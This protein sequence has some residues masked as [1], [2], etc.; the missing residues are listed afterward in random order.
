MIVV[1]I[2]AN[3]TKALLVISQEQNTRNSMIIKNHPQLQKYISLSIGILGWFMGGIVFGFN[4]YA[5][6]L[7][8]TFN[9]TQTEL[10]YIASSGDLGM[11]LSFPP[12]MLFDT[13]GPRVT[14]I[15]SFILTTMGF[16]LM[17]L[18]T[19]YRIFFSSNNWLLCII[20]FLASEGTMFIIIATSVVNCENFDRKHR[21]KV[22]GL[23]NIIYGVSPAIFSA[24]YEAL[25]IQ[26]HI[27]DPENQKLG[28]FMITLAVLS[29]C[30]NLYA[31]VMLET[32]QKETDKPGDVELSRLCRTNQN[33]EQANYGTE[34][35]LNKFP[36]ET[37]E[38]IN[39]RTT[40]V[41][42]KTTK[43]LDMKSW[44][45]I[46]TPEFYFIWLTCLL[47]G[48]AGGTCTNNITTVVKSAKFD[49]KTTLFTV[50]IPISAL[51][52]RFLGGAIPDYVFQKWPDIP[53]SSILLFPCIISCIGQLCF[54]FFN[55][56]YIGLILSSVLMSLAYGSFYP[57]INI[58]TIEYFGL[59]YFGQ[60]SGLIVM[61]HGIGIVV[62][63]KLFALNYET[64]SPTESSDCYGEM[65]TKWY[66]LLMAILCSCAIF[67]TLCLMKIE[68]DE[69]LQHEA[70]MNA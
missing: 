54:T 61:G 43:Q 48:G 35:E 6:A 27:E 60:N 22:L 18:A 4:A 68:K 12:G 13:F 33:G 2:G 46:Q 7:K 21:G 38:E 42:K 65:C 58:L 17:W 31:V 29:A 37:K 14:N 24:L 19:E 47:I 1:K 8:K 63:Q 5:I 66:F 26:G 51:L 49:T 10:E 9:Y 36:L 3:V 16:A 15:A 70:T 11:C 20:Y 50:I 34:Y 64:H 57:Q 44:E 30:I 41:Q 67:I 69:R 55:Q 39:D 28:E 53:K 40:L 45:I 62:F 32:V 23:L 52:T 56:S 59:K 25:Y